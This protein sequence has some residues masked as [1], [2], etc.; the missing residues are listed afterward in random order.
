VSVNFNPEALLKS[1]Y[2]VSAEDFDQQTYDRLSD[3]LIDG[4]GFRPVAYSA[5]QPLVG[6]TLSIW[7]QKNGIYGI[8]TLEMLDWLRKQIRGRRALEIGAGNGVFGRSL[9]IPM[10][11][12]FHQEDTHTRTF[13]EFLQTK[14]V[15]YG[16]DVQRMDAAEAVERH[17][18][19]V[20]LGVWVTSKHRDGDKIGFEGGID[21]H[22]ILAV[23][24]VRAYIT[25]GNIKHLNS[26]PIRHETPKGWLC[27]EYKL[28]FHVSR[29]RSQTNNSVL[30]W[31]RKSN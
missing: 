7:A 19:Q 10:F 18:P 1:A 15:S 27:T 30:V 13:Y 28:P 24:S 31:N 11:D 4:D 14:P 16:Q 12:S 29:T 23:P 3:L 20:V 9:G 8:P 5:I 21:E 22:R 2:T 6:P 17:R 26:K 25:L